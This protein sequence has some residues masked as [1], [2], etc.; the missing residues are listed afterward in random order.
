MLAGLFYTYL[1]ANSTKMIAGLF[2]AYPQASSTEM[3]AGLFDAYSI[4]EMGT[5]KPSSVADF[6]EILVLV[7]Q[8][9][10]PIPRQVAPK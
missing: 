5:Y 2:D 8:L 3:I 10:T 9:M 1:K 4:L 7:Y 6:K